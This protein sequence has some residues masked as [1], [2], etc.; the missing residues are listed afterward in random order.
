MRGI[1]IASCQLKFQKYEEIYEMLINAFEK[2]NIELIKLYNDELMLKI[3]YKDINADFI[4]FWDKDIKLCRYLENS[5]LQVFNNSSAIEICDD[6]GLTALELA[7]HKIKMPKQILSPKLFF[8]KLS[9]KYLSDIEKE[10]DYPIVVKGIVGSFGKQVFLAENYNELKEK[11]FE[12]G[13]EGIVF[14]ELIKSS[15]GKDIR[16]QIVGNKAIASVAR[17]AKE[18]QLC[19]NVTAG[20]R[21]EKINA[22]KSYIELAEKVSRILKLDFCGVDMLIG[23][24]GEPILLEVN[25]NAHF[26]N[27]YDCTGINTAEYIADY[28]IRKVKNA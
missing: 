2:R 18:G 23:N 7:K 25:S 10:I 17:F 26:K 8:D 27:L 12:F 6:K 9:E 22:P 11:A 21:M 4:I 19:S 20:G 15:Y 28:V 14:Q 24:N 5:G 16:V 1:I 3:G 13:C